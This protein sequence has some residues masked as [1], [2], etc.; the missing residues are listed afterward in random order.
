MEESLEIAIVGGGIAG[1]SLA[2]G[3]H[4]RNINVKVYE[5]GKS[6]RE[7][8][9]GIGFTSNAER[10]ML[11]LDPRIYH[12]FKKVA[13]QNAS[14]WYYWV[15]ASDYSGDGMNGNGLSED[16]IHKM[17]LGPRGFEGCHR[18]AFLDEIVKLLPVERV[19]FDKGLVDIVDGENS[20][21]LVLKFSDGTV[22][23]ADAVIGCDGIRSRVRQLI[24]GED[25]PAS[26]PSYTHKY[27][28]RGLVP[29]E[30]AKEIFSYKKAFSRH[31]HIGY[32]AH[33]VTFPVAGGTLLN[34]VA[35]VT[36]TNPW[37]FKEKLTAPGTKSEAVAAFSKFHPTFRAIIHL[38]PEELS[39][40]AVFDMKDHPAPTY[41]RGCIAVCGDAAHA[42]S[43][44]HGAGAGFAIED[45][46]VLA[47]LFENAAGKKRGDRARMVRA[48]LESYS[49]VRLERTQWLVEGSR[50]MGEMYEWQ[51]G[52]DRERCRDEIEW[53][54]RRIW[55]FD[56]GKMVVDAVGV[57]EG[58]LDQLNGVH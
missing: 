55:D 9:A 3:L 46:L 5:R 47:E 23:R 49:E 21:K 30:K 18:A 52:R 19:V 41:S 33:A 1:I 42:S 15:D 14:D 53:R 35:F 39:K 16:L 24:L 38:L 45:A 11:A 48:V 40:W 4:T 50:F 58:K 51:H 8:G 20:G 22:E 2:L 26:Y 29:M 56:V 27:A 57:F 37:P 44:Y 34:V 43:P 28:F 7:I 31:I 13:A 25:N 17:D 54:S 12:A 6:L 10:A 32:D 36:D